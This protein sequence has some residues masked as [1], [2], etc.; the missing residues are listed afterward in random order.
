MHAYVQS[1]MALCWL[2]NISLLD[3]TMSL[4]LAQCGD[5]MTLEVARK[6]MNPKFFNPR[7]S[8]ACS[9]DVIHPLFLYILGSEDK[10][11]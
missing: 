9:G 2:L 10:I 6:N 11:Y 7:A 3:K 1:F 8:L 5:C 4:Y